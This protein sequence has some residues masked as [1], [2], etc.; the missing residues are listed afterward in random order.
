MDGVFACSV[1]ICFSLAVFRSMLAA[2]HLLILKYAYAQ[3]TPGPQLL[4][5]DA[6]RPAAN[7]T[8]SAVRVHL[9]ESCGAG[10]AEAQRLHRQ[11][12]AK[13]RR[14]NRVRTGEARPD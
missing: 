14:R 12:E 13:G 9:H 1:A 2:P 7:R 8:D 11:S 6:L 10:A 4:C 3:P 5:A